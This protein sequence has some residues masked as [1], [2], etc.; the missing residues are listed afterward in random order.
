M[1]LQAIQWHCCHKIV[2]QT[3]MR[4]LHSS[5]TLRCLA[6]LFLG[7]SS[8]MSA[9]N[10]TSNYLLYVGVY[11]KGIYSYRYNPS[12]ASLQPLGIA[13]E[14]PNPSFITADREGRYLYAVSE[15]DG[16]HPGAVGAFKIDSATGKLTLLNQQSSEG[17]APCHLSVD[18]STKLLAAANYGTGTVPVF[19]IEKD[20][21]LG[22]AVEVLSAQGSGADPKRQKGPHAHQIVLSPGNHF[23]YVPDLGLDQ[24]RIYK[25]DAAAHK[26]APAEPAFV[27]EQPGMGP[28][29]MVFSHDGKHAYVINELKSFVTAFNVDKSTGALTPFQSLP[30]SADG[31]ETD[32]AAEILLHPNGKFLYASVRFS[33]VLAV[34]AVDGGSGQLRPVQNTGSG[35]TF[36]RGVEFDPSGKY[37]FVGDQKAN[38]FTIFSV[39]GATGQL[40]P[41]GKKF[42]VP[43][44]VAFLF[45]PAK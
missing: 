44:P 30:A 42:D 40:T 27:K 33:G 35:G 4:L 36:P 25:L 5:S 28:R 12:D 3:E 21:S 43:A 9:A 19:P 31:H 1:L 11:G 41:T 22:K 37:L 20:G 6:I 17:V 7:L 45:V 23:L 38:N 18:S 39:D 16:N 8:L 29:H 14:F 34:Y 13:G 15:V 32:G 24:V 10:S 26:V 2:E